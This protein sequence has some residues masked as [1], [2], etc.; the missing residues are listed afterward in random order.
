M[1]KSPSKSEPTFKQ[2]RTKYIFFSMILTKIKHLDCFWYSI[3]TESLHSP[4]RKSCNWSPR[5]WLFCS[6]L[7]LS[8]VHPGSASG[9]YRHEMPAFLARSHLYKS[10]TS[11]RVWET[12]LCKCRKE[13]SKS[14]LELKEVPNLEQWSIYQCSE[15]TLSA[16]TVV[17]SW[18][19]CAF[20]S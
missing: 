6:L 7:E 5:T 13:Q 11:Q 3:H 14:L 1:L 2:F 12:Q 4:Y 15:R 8:A 16:T 17:R 20:S 9:S 10:N 18:H 19:S